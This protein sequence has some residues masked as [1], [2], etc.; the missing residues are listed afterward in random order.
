MV[1]ERRLS[2][3]VYD[4]LKQSTSIRR[5]SANWALCAGYMKKIHYNTN[6][7]II[8]C[9]THHLVLPAMPASHHQSREKKQ[10]LV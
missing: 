9:Y 8:I 10:Y 1:V 3:L 5:Y 6:M 7:V 4:V 2:A